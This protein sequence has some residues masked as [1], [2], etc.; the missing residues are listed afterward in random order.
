MARRGNL[1]RDKTKSELRRLK[2][3]P[4]KREGQNFMLDP[5]YIDQILEFAAIK[6]DDQVVEIGPGLGALTER[7]ARKPDLTVIEI[8]SNFS[9]D[10]TRKF[11]EIK[12]INADVLDL[13][14]STLGQNL[15]LVGNLP[16]SISSPLLFKIIDQYHCIRRSVFLLQ[17]EFAE[18]VGAN[19]GSKAYGSLTVF[20]QLYFDMRLGPII[21]PEAFFPRPKVSS[22]LIELTTLTAP[23]LQLTDERLFKKLVKASFAKRR[24]TIFNNL[25]ALFDDQALKAALAAAEI[26]PMRRAETLTISDFHRL[27]IALEPTS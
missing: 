6:P 21:S 8:E 25:K 18:R 3:R 5:Q 4:S 15:T 9:A 16:Y 1:A 2:V 7:L 22:R 12:V 17:K 10:L 20:A 23:R 11:P 24:K 27:H 13:D 26:D 14:F 19:P